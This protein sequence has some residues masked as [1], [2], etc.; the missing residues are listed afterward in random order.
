MINFDAVQHNQFSSN[1][2][3]QNGFLMRLISSLIWAKKNFFV[4]DAH[5]GYKRY[6]RTK[7][8]FLPESTFLA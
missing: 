3:K 8:F 5:A 1:L 4:A 7:N 2:Q 6:A